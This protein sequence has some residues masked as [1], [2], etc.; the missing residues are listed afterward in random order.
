MQDLARA[1]H[2]LMS[3]HSS[4]TLIDDVGAA[5]LHSWSD[6]RRRYHDLV[7]LRD[8]LAYVDVLADAA[9]YAWARQAIRERKLD[10]ILLTVGTNGWISVRSNLNDPAYENKA[11]PSTE[12]GRA[13]V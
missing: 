4:S 12:I 6:P 8:I 7:H 13:H 9:D 1:W 10:A 5:L 2:T 11:K 3:R